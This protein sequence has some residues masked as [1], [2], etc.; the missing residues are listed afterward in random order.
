[1]NIIIKIIKSVLAILLLLCV[2]KMPYGYYELVRFLSLIGFGCLSFISY[3]KGNQNEMIVYFSLAL[4]FQPFIKVAL[5]KD[6]WNIIDVLV[7]IGLIFSIFKKQQNNKL[8]LNYLKYF[9]LSGYV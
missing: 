4:L 8:W 5:G 1:M 3:K 2:F 6:I 7:S 9:W